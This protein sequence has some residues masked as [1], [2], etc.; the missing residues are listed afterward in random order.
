MVFSLSGGMIL[1]SAVYPLYSIKQA[2]GTLNGKFGF[3]FKI[4]M[5]RSLS[6]L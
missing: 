3:F 5:I 6:L 1:A 2:K 4:L